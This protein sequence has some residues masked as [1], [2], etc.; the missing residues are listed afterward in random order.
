M[1]FI[2][3][4]K[5]LQTSK[6]KIRKIIVILFILFLILFSKANQSNLQNT[7]NYG[8]FKDFDN[9]RILIDKI[10]PYNTNL[11]LKGSNISLRYSTYQFPSIYQ[12]GFY[13]SNQLTILNL[14]PVLKF[15]YDN[16]DSQMN[17]VIDFKDIMILSTNY[18]EYKDRRYR[19]KFFIV[20]KNN[21]Y[22]LINLVS[23]NDY[24]RSVVPSEMPVSWDMEALKAQAIIART[25]AIRVALERRKKNEVF[26]LYSTVMDQA[27]YGVDK[28]NPKT[29]MAVQQTD[30]LIIVYG[31]YPIWAL[32]HSNCGGQTLDG[33]LVFPTRLNKNE[34]YLTSVKCLYQ[35]KEWENKV[36]TYSLKKAIEKLTKTKVYSIDNIYTN[37]FRTYV[38]YNGGVIYSLY[39]WEVRKFLGYSVVRS[40]YLREIRVEGGYI[41]F[42][43]IGFGHGVGLCQ[44]GANVLAKNGFKCEEIIKYYYKGVEIIDKDRWLKDANI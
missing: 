3:S 31:G 43:G 14:N 26:D 24:L 13:L 42:K 34:N 7:L 16:N 9:L 27:Y 8:D 21:E 12:G 10:N 36:E 40:P 35:G 37:N 4:Y 15:Y 44:F 17:E 33:R 19:G 23:M 29:D 41:N 5:P 28:E 22:Y 1:Q 39:N 38:V 30:N 11:T 25:Y 20:N 32:Y 6:P 18:I 2:N